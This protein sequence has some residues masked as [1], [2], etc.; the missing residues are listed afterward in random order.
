MLEN[1]LFAYRSSRH[2][3]TKCSPF[4]LMYGRDAHLPIDRTRVP[5]NVNVKELD[6]ETKVQ[7]MLELQKKLH[8]KVRNHIENAQARHKRQYDAKHNT[9]TNVNVG[10]KVL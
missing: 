4:L 7:K 3:S 10:D 2:E 5:G 8:D 9:N 6:F 1:V